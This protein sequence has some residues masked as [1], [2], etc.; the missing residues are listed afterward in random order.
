MTELGYRVMCTLRSNRL[1]KCPV[2]TDKQFE[3]KDRG[4]SEAFIS[5]DETCNVIAWKDS[6]RVL[7]GSN[8][9]ETEPKETL[10]RWDK[11]KRCKVDVTAPQITNQYHKFMDGVD[12]MDMLV[13]LHSIPFKSKLWYM[14]I[15]WRIFDLIVINSRILMNSRRDDSYGST[16][17]GTFR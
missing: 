10:R 12:T 4:F 5:D 9:S 14:R 17:H 7:L 3:T 2:S 16:S 11:V 13:V 1:E 8:H 15:I 6:K